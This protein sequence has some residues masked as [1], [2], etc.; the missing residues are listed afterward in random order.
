MTH[1][2]KQKVKV[3][4]LLLQFLKKKTNVI[5]Q[6]YIKKIVLIKKV[7]KLEIIS[8]HVISIII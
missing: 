3:Q 4:D 1:I 5:I 7:L 8:Q 6:I 2:L